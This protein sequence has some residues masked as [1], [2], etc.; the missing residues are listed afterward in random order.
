MSIKLN[1]IDTHAH[2]YMSRFDDDRKEVIQRAKDRGIKKIMLPGVSSKSHEAL[3]ELSKEYEDYCLPMIGLHPTSVNNNP[4]WR[5]ELQIIQNY[6]ENPPVKRFYAIGEIGLDMH[7]SKDFYLEQREA[8]EWQMELAI[9]FDLPIVIHTR[10]AWGPMAQSLRRYSK[11]GLRGVIHS[12]LG[13]YEDYLTISKLGD[14]V[15]GIP[16]VVTYK[17]SGLPEAL[18][19]IP[20]EDIV[21]ETDAP[22]LTPEPFRGKRNE[23]SYVFHICLKLAE[24]YGRPAAEIANIT[25]TN[26]ERIFDI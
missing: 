9:D 3:I 10:D 6:I 4:N 17:N 26:A 5:D 18:R 14:F 2:L 12:F 19:N 1:L 8:F 23:S 22:Y 13:T 16:G 20:I 24:I 11:H 25:T 15:F 21:I 7:W